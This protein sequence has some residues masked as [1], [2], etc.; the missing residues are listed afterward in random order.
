MSYWQL[1]ATDHSKELCRSEAWPMPSP[2]LH[3]ASAR[4]QVVCERAHV[5]T[6]VCP[7]MPRDSREVSLEASWKCSLLGSSKGTAYI[8]LLPCVQPTPYSPCLSLHSFCLQGSGLPLATRGFGVHA[9]MVPGIRA[10]N[11]SAVTSLPA[12]DQARWEPGRSQEVH[13]HHTA[14]PK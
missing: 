12:V 4:G 10:S 8:G 9:S 7:P 2:L 1:P 13:Q 11:L 3:S 5:C 6:C 14:Q